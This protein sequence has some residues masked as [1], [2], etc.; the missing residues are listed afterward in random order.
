MYMDVL[1][2]DSVFLFWSKRDFDNERATHRVR[3]KREL[4]ERALRER[5]R[6]TERERERERERESERESDRV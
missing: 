6:R 5:G 4:R 3:E 2:S 1:T